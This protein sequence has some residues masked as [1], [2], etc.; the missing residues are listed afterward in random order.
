MR[1]LPSR[2][3]K[4]FLLF[5]ITVCRLAYESHSSLYRLHDASRR[6][7][8]SHSSLYKF[9]PLIYES[10]SSLYGSMISWQPAWSFIDTSQILQK[11]FCFRPSSLSGNQNFKNPRTNR[12]HRTTQ[13]LFSSK[14]NDDSR[15]SKIVYLM[16]SFDNPMV[17]LR[18]SLDHNVVIL[19]HSFDNP[20][21]ILRHSLDNLA[22]ILRGGAHIQKGKNSFHLIQ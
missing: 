2:M 7:Y 6:I 17:L 22:V 5:F 10:H 3:L 8:E 16:N 12:T 11:V 20:A 19:S 21:V 13:N 9:E 14:N 4:L 1:N 15:I 18:H